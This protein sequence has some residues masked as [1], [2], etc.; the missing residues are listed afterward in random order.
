MR[1]LVFGFMLCL[2]GCVTPYGKMGFMGGV[3]AQPIDGAVIR[4]SA[5]G[6]GFTSATR[7]TEFIFLKSAEEALRHRY[8]GFVFVDN[9]DRTRLHI[10]GGDLMYKPGQ[11]VLVRLLNADEL[12]ATSGAYNALNV[13][14][15]LAPRYIRTR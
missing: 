7:I 11:D 4:I 14:N 9:A 12:S 8:A 10:N 5:R 2:T 13:W 6:N 3:S 15:N 1:I